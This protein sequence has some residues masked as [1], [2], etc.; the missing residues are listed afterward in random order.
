MSRS[1]L[2]DSKPCRITPPSVRIKEEADKIMFHSGDLFL[3][4]E[5][6]EAAVYRMCDGTITVKEMI[7]QLATKYD[8]SESE[9]SAQ[10]EA[11][12]DDLAARDLISWN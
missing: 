5:E 3:L 12:L 6:S 7:A 9:V 4:M 11:F 1:V 10:L 2:L 8:T